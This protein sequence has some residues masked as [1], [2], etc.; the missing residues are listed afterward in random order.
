MRTLPRIL[1]LPELGA[2]HD[3][4]THDVEFEGGNSS[5]LLTKPEAVPPVVH[6]WSK[7][8]TV[9]HPDS[10]SMS[11][12]RRSLDTTSHLLLCG[13]A[14]AVGRVP[15][16]VL[17]AD[18]HIVGLAELIEVGT[19]V[20]LFEPACDCWGVVEVVLN[21]SGR[22]DGVGQKGIRPD[23]THTLYGSVPW[24]WIIKGRCPRCSGW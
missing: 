17:T 20:G 11:S 7:G 19:A 5:K 10:S 4:P 23:L 1:T 6:S 18:V 24:S 21:G 16:V 9:V 14:E 12:C 3:R 8:L 22:F 15:H 2:V 13:A